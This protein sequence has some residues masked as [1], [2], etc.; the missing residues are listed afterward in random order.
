MI[1]FALVLLIC[2][3]FLSAFFS[4]SETGFYRAHRLRFVVDSMAGDRLAKLLLWLFNN[5]TWFVSTALVGN[6]IANYMVSLAIVLLASLIGYWA[7]F[8]FPILLTP[9][10]FVIGELFPKQLFFLS[11]NLLLR[12]A[13]PLFAFFAVLFAPI[14]FLL[15]GMSYLMERWIGQ[16]PV[17]IKTT[18]ARRELHQFLREGQEAGV[19]L[20]IQRQL[21]ESFLLL[22]SKP[23]R[24]FCRPLSEIEF[25][26]DDCS[27]EESQ[28]V[29]ERFELSA[30]PIV[31]SK[32]HQLVGYLK[33]TDLLFE[34][35]KSKPVRRIRKLPEMKSTELFGEALIQMHSG[36]DTMMK[37]VGPQ[38]QVVGLV[39]LQYLTEQMLESRVDTL[40]E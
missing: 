13:A 29:A 5:P 8:A 30:I 16:S 40:E 20:A 23:I 21:A 15:R 25:V 38:G 6:N 3:F 33:S 11:P 10:L 2:G 24:E 22:A 17:K 37:I 12:F 32:S 26:R 4:G 31:K 18:V 36:E 28:K 39:T 7:E 14:S 34:K 19:L 35:A 9:V 1:A 27:A